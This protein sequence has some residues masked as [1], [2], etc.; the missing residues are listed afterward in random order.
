MRSVNLRIAVGPWINESHDDRGEWSRAAFCW[1]FGQPSSL[2][3][4]KWLLESSGMLVKDTDKD[5]D[6]DGLA[7]ELHGGLGDLPP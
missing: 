5:D 6:D 1:E 4:T 2:G 3:P 7:L